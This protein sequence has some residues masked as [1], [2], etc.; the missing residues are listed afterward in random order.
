VAEFVQTAI[1]DGVATVTIDR[2]NVH[3]AFNEVVIDELTEAFAAAGADDAVRVVILA[4]VGHSFSAGADI[5]WMKRMVDYTVA[6]NV[7]D[8]GAMAAMLRAIRECPKPV[9]AR[10]H[11]ATFGGGV[12]LTAACDLAVCVRDATFALTEV[13]LGILPAVISPY[14]QEKIGPGAMRRYAL[15]AERFDG[16]EAHRIG[17]VSEVVESAAELDERI[18]FFVKLIK[19]NG[20]EAVAACKAV[21]RDIQPVDWDAATDATTRAIAER[22]V[23]A[24]GQD[25]L[26]AF[27]E[28]R[29][30]GWEGG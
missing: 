21:L 8:A 17:L 1:E 11:G 18:A 9:I 16:E 26:H 15:T 29:K 12:G 25:G 27:L 2:P 20:P 14:V 28:K 6:E 30:P 10:V 22:R 19:K 13:R 5:H 23:S 3:N 24:E 4:S 7:R